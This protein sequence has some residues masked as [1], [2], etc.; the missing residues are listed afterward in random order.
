MTDLYEALGVPKSADEETIRKAYRRQAK[1]AHPDGGGSVAQFSLVKLALD[2]LTDDARRKRYDETGQAESPQPD[3]LEA[4]ALNAVHQMVDLVVQT[5][6]E[7]GI[8]LD[9][10]DVVADSIQTIKNRLAELDEAHRQAK[11]KIEPARRLAARFKSKRG[12]VNRIGPMMMAR[13][14]YLEEVAANIAKDRP[15][16]VRAM[17]ILADHTYDYTTTPPASQMWAEVPG[18]IRINQP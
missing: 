10:L 7:R 2:T 16:L 13:V 6:E 4:Q 9:Q 11:A 15:T 14:G 17:E 12:K 5:A 8:P 18:W 3:T 1:A